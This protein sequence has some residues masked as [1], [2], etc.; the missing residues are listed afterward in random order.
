MK[1]NGVIFGIIFRNNWNRY[2]V[3]FTNFLLKLPA[4]T[5]VELEIE[6][7]QSESVTVRIE[8]NVNDV[9]LESRI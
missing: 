4:R 5:I 3:A 1:A 9:N 7:L 8:K 2:I 6:K